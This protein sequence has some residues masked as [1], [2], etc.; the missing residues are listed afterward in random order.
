MI[1][2]KART[3]VQV[4][5]KVMQLASSL[6]LVEVDEAYKL[7]MLLRKATRV[8]NPKGGYLYDTFLLTVVGS[9]LTG[10]HKLQCV[11]CLDTKKQ[12]VYNECP[13]CTG[14]GCPTCNHEGL[15]RGKIPCQ[16]CNPKIIKR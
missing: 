6:G 13:H 1:V 15:L 3:Q 8:I 16:D 10:V 9:A 4:T 12:L 7:P 14:V 11:H 5:A 2:R